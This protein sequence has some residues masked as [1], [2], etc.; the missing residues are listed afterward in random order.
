MIS[1]QIEPNVGPKLASWIWSISAHE[2]IVAIRG[3]M[4]EAMN[5]SGPRTS[6]RTSSPAIRLAFGRRLGNGVRNQETS[7]HPSSRACVLAATDRLVYGTVT[8]KPKS[9]PNLG[10]VAGVR[11]ESPGKVRKTSGI[12]RPRR[13]ARL[14]HHLAAF[15]IPPRPF[16]NPSLE[17]QKSQIM[18]TIRARLGGGRSHM[19]TRSFKR[20]NSRL[21]V[22]GI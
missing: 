13:Q 8:G 16:L 17:E 9:M 20:T 7:G 19:S 15:A 21:N 12:H 5:D 3:G 6:L 1:A 10:S 11:N 14:T 18:E 4:R 2:L 22:G